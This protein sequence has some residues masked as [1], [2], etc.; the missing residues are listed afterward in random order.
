MPSPKCDPTRQTLQVAGSA[1]KLSN[2]NAAS[3]RGWTGS[4]IASTPCREKACIDDY[5][6]EQRASSLISHTI[7]SKPAIA[8][9][10]RFF[11]MGMKSIL[12]AQEV[13]RLKLQEVEGTADFRQVQLMANRRMKVKYGEYDAEY[14]QAEIDAVKERLGKRFSDAFREEKDTLRGLH[15]VAEIILLS[16]Y[17]DFI[18]GCVILCNSVMIGM[19]QT[20]RIERNETYVFQYFETAFLLVYIAEIIT[21]FFVC[22][23]S[24]V[25]DHWVKF[26]IFLVTVSIASEWILN[27]VLSAAN[28]DQLGPVMVMRTAR[29]ARLARA[30]RLLV[31]F[32]ELWMLV[33]GLLLSANMM[34]Y[35]MVL[36]CILIYMFATI[37]IEL[38]TLDTNL[39]ASDAQY[40]GIVDS[41]FRSLP[42]TMLSLIQFVTMDSIGAIYRPLVERQPYLAI[43][44][45]LIILV[46]SVVAMN[47]VTAVLVNGALEQANQDKEMM[48]AVETQRKEQLMKDLY[49]M[50][51]RLDKDQSGLLESEELINASKE[52]KSKLHE[53]CELADPLEVFYQLDVD[54]GGCLDVDEFCDGLYECAVSKTPIQLK[55]MDKLMSILR[56]NQDLMFE[57]LKVMHQHILCIVPPSQS[58]EN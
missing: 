18:V 3:Y 21:R 55:R 27:P 19:E 12:E 25:N 40:L 13:R 46:V 28:M 1:S 2:A 16:R 52:D 31:K 37:A 22:G 38:I 4:S 15:R 57:E 58:A 34:V 56:R 26:D 10:P 6:P 41:Y 44:F 53:F 8:G 48:R 30:L 32:R 9:T 20:A 5:Q 39:N 14:S 42:V 11:R 45:V 51:N 17:F 35:T 7:S 36:L 24:A 23:I 47:I 50:F 49:C 33:R 29:L 54:Q 43:Y